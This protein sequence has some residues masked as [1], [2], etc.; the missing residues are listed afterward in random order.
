MRGWVLVSPDRHENPNNYRTELFELKLDGSATIRHF[1]HAGTS[2]AVTNSAYPYGCASPDG[3]KIAFN[4]DWYF[5][6]AHNNARYDGRA[7]IVEY[8]EGANKI[9]SG[10]KTEAS[11]TWK[12]SQNYPNPFNPTTM[13][14]YTL[15]TDGMTKLSIYNVLGQEVKVLVNE[16]MRAGSYSTPFDGSNLS[17]GIYFYK[18]ESNNQMQVKKMLLLK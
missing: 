15:P 9:A 7:Y 17:S 10:K 3:K 11:L 14:D 18:L 1:G 2:A 4:S 13:I 6:G 16:N 8:V 12:L 5:M